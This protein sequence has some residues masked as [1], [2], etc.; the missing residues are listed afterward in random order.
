MHVFYGGE[1][2]SKFGEFVVVRGEKRTCA[3][4]LLQVLDD[5]PG[6]GE[7]IKSG[8]A[9]ADFVEK[10]EAGGCGVVEDDGDF[11]HF[12]EKR[13][14]AASQIVAGADAR[15]DAVGD[16]KL[17]LPCG[18]EAASLRHENDER[19]LPKI[20][21]FAAHVR[22]GN[23]KKLLAA[24]LEA[25]IVGNEALTFLAKEFFDDRVA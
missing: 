25:E 20:G 7:A 24:G 8:G 22:A 4:V 3:G 18:N 5:G 9:P 14:T 16:G 1:K 19:G 13:G 11:A 15:E 2:I 12:D 6:D 23:E 10:Y 21:R 17:G